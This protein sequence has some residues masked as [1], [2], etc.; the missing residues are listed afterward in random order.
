VLDL[1]TVVPRP[2][3]GEEAE[4]EL[5]SRLMNLHRRQFDHMPIRH[6]RRV[7]DRRAQP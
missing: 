6:T 7:A 3:R 4:H 5:A 2:G 1:D